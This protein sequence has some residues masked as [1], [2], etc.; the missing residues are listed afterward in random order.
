[1]TG[2]KAPRLLTAAMREVVA[3]RANMV[4]DAVVQQNQQEAGHRV[5]VPCFITGSRC[6]VH[7]VTWRARRREITFLN[8]LCV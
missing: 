2:R 4:Q 1:M 6:V 8:R 5:V 7:V 3:R